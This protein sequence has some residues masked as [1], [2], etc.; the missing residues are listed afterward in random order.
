VPDPFIL[1]EEAEASCLRSISFDHGDRIRASLH[2]VMRDH[3]VDAEIFLDFGA[4]E[5]HPRARTSAT[6]LET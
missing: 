3:A 6:S 1:D 2:A 5:A 4:S